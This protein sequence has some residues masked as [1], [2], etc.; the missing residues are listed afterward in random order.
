MFTHQFNNDPT[1]LMLACLGGGYHAVDAFIDTT[2]QKHLRREIQFTSMAAGEEECTWVPSRN[3]WA[4]KSSGNVNTGGG[5]EDEEDED[6]RE[7]GEPEQD[8]D[9]SGKGKGKAKYKVPSAVVGANPSPTRATKESPI[10]LAMYAQLSS[11][12]KSYQSALCEFDLSRYLTYSS[13]FRLV[14]LF[15]AYDIQ[16][17]DAVICLSLAVASIARAMQRQADNRQ[18]LI[19]QA[20]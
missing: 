9:V 12:A 19:A 20:S 5:S 18:H 7:E 1:R 4:F 8:E 6:V 3:R 14:Y 16:P 10:L 11:C 17:D 2:F 15:Q 13:F